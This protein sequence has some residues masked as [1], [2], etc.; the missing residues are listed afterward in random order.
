[1][2]AIIQRRLS[3]AAHAS[4]T[5]AVI[6]EVEERR[7]RNEA[8]D[9]AAITRELLPIW[10]EWDRRGGFAPEVDHAALFAAW[11]RQDAQHE[12]AR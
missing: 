12:C 2:N 8:S 9:P 5:A 6:E 10:A 1:M 3:Q 7:T 11:E 4:L